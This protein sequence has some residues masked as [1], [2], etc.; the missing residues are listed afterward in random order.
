MKISSIP[1]ILAIIIELNNYRICCALLITTVILLI[2]LEK[3]FG[4]I[5]IV[6]RTTESNH[7]C[8]PSPKCHNQLTVSFIWLL[9]PWRSISR[10]WGWLNQITLPV[11]IRPIIFIWYSKIFGCNLREMENKNLKEYRN[12]SEFFRR[13]LMPNVRPINHCADLV[14]WP[15]WKPRLIDWLN[16]HPLKQ[17]RLVQPMVLSYNSKWYR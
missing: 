14:S 3:L 4:A 16:Y 11:F 17:F 1:P 12:L 13:S 2:L 5:H 15:F 10:L 6:I 9:L 8:R 7:H